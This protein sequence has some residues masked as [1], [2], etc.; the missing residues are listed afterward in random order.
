MKVRKVKITAQI[1][2]SVIVMFFVVLLV[3]GSISYKALKK[4]IYDSTRA[5]AMN[6]AKVAAQQ[7]DGD[8]FQ[9]ITSED[10]DGYEEAH[11]E[12]SLFFETSD[13]KY[14][15]AYRAK[16]DENNQLVI[17]A[18]PEDPAEVG[19]DYDN[20]EEMSDAL[21][22]KVTAD[23]APTTDEWGT[24]LSGFAP[25]SDSKGKVV[26]A[27]GIDIAAE[28]IQVTLNNL[29][30]QIVI[31]FVICFFVVLAGISLF[32]IKLKRN[33]VLLNN[34][35]KDII[36]TDGDLTKR[37]EITSGNELEVIGNNFNVLLEKVRNTIDDTKESSQQI[38]NNIQDISHGMEAMKNNIGD[39]NDNIN[40]IVAAV[41]QTQSSVD[42]TSEVSAKMH[43]TS[44]EMLHLMKSNKDT[45]NEINQS[46]SQM[47]DA[48]IA[49]NHAIIAEIKKLNENLDTE[50][51][52]ANA[53][54]RI[55]D[56]SEKILQISTQTNLLSLNASIEA[57]RAGEAGKG[58]AVVAGEIS[59][60]ASETQSAVNEIQAVNS[61]VLSAVEGLLALAVHMVDYINDTVLGDYKMFADSSKEFVSQTDKMSE[62]VTSMQNDMQRLYEMISGIN[63]IVKNIS[64]ASSDNNS[65]IMSIAS[66]V[67]DFRDIVMNTFETE[68]KVQKTVLDINQ[69]LNQYVTR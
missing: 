48:A 67:S 27:V 1:C 43:T 26:G 3:I 16:D 55:T 51:Q 29:V 45:S 20:Y 38:S 46:S 33:F 39:I 31:G 35:I 4:E 53:V 10:S 61:E 65:E 58:F 25:I 36:S 23:A 2:I 44:E 60:L 21:T 13:I 9:N 37:V 7:I 17:D 49:S 28:D 54:E 64:A 18:D 68:E 63:E 66:T 56:L 15:Y 47:Y 11:A 32:S 12:L 62:N 22:G 69:N 6:Y 5:K 52:K 30:R 24:V 59:T 42:E 19:E 34:K 50:K 8:K 41:E 14:V 57:A 40:S